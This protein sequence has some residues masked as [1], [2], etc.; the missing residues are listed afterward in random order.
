MQASESPRANETVTG[1]E[2]MRD[3]FRPSGDAGPRCAVMPF[4]TAGYPDLEA[5]RRFLA[6]A[7]AAGADLVEVGI[8][9]SDPIADGPVIAESMHE[10][11]L[12][13]VTP[14]AI[15]EMTAGIP[16]APPL[17]AMVSIS[18]IERIGAAEFVAHAVEAGFAGFIVPDADP[19]AARELASLVERHGA[20]WCP[21]VSPT[22]SEPRRRELAAS[23]TGFL[24]LLARVGITGERSDAPDVGDGVAALRAVSR[25]PVAVGF[26]I[27]RPEHVEAVARHADGAIVGSAIVRAMRDARASGGDAVD[28]ALALVRSLA[29]AAQRKS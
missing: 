2:R 16:D 18:I 8:P 21:L 26:G 13:G 29:E 23:A 12:A 24:Y 6:G 22:T 25:V 15:F 27:S 20:G 28:A 9:F 10:A 11:L 7:R 1:V 17:V 19:V 14:A 4:V 3:A 5:T